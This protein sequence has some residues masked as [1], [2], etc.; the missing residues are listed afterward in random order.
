MFSRSC[1][2]L[3]ELQTVVLWGVLLP[4]IFCNNN[5]LKFY[6][7]F[8]LKRQLA[9][10]CYFVGIVPFILTNV[11]SRASKT[12]RTLKK[13]WNHNVRI[14]GMFALY[15]CLYSSHFQKQSGTGLFFS[16][17]LHSNKCV[18]LFIWKKTFSSCMKT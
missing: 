7:H 8:F 11:C 10:N 3:Q 16:K 9:S 5:K 13:S 14:W 2:R 4:H 18:L 6:P 15:L 12:Q 17:N 1:K